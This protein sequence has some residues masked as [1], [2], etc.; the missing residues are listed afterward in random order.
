VDDADLDFSQN[1]TPSTYAD[2]FQTLLV[3][4]QQ[5]IAAGLGIS[6]AT[7]GTGL[8]RGLE[9]STSPRPDGKYWTSFCMALLLRPRVTLRSK[10]HLR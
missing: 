5:D 3:N 1:L 2:G 4:Y 9:L 6:P 7:F 8:F 10:E